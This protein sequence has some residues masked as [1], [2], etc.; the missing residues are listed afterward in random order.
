ML[1]MKAWF[2]LSTFIHYGRTLLCKYV[3]QTYSSN[4]TLIL[5][6]EI[7]ETQKY[8][9]KSIV[10]ITPRYEVHDVFIRWN[11]HAMM[12]DTT[13]CPFC[14]NVRRPVDIW[15]LKSHNGTWFSHK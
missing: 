7:K 6:K 15:Q 14:M 2:K 5:N 12:L 11:T 3:I 10:G 4:I 9:T 1:A 13:R 8:H